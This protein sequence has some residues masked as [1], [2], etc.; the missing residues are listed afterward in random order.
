MKRKRGFAAKISD[1]QILSVIR[2]LDMFDEK[3]ELK[4]KN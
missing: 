3:N 1:D 4:K 2:E